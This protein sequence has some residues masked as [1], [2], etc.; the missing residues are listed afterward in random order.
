MNFSPYAIFLLLLLLLVV[1]LPCAEGSINPNPKFR[2][3]KIW[4]IEEP[5]SVLFST[6]GCIGSIISLAYYTWLVHKNRKPWA[7]YDFKIC[8]YVP[9]LDILA[10]NLTSMCFHTKETWLNEKLDYA[11]AILVPFLIL[12][13]GIVRGLEITQRSKQA[14]VFGISLAGF[15]WHEYEMLAV[16][17][18]YGR[19]MKLGA[20]LTVLMAAVW[21]AWSA[22]QLYKKKNPHS[23]WMLYSIASIIVLSPFE[24][25]DFIPIWGFFDAHSLW[26]A[27][28]NIIS[29]SFWMFSINDFTACIDDY[30]T[31]LS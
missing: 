14:L 8:Y 23:K 6:I 4:G 1:G 12:P 18:D 31:K 24:I 5:A 13:A 19:H 17:F 28:I 7:E 9:T 15:T 20:V 26:H 29:F 11:A 27:S 16:L 10:V 25:R 21:F 2:V 3:D 30:Y 22:T